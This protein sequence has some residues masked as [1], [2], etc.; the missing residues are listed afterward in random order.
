MV[1]DAEQARRLAESKRSES[2]KMAMDTIHTA[3]WQGFNEVV[4]F[5]CPPSFD[6]VKTL[7]DKGFSVNEF[8]HPLEQRKLVKVSW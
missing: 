6:V 2:L 4:L 5:G 3:A 1:Q 8:V 7:L